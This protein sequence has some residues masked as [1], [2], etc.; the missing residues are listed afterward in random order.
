MTDFN[1]NI[2]SNMH[3]TAHTLIGGCTGSGKSVLINS[4]I[5]YEYQAYPSDRFIFIDP[6]RV[7]LIKYRDTRPCYLYASENADIINALKK[8]IDVMETAY[9]EM[10]AKGLNES[11][12]AHLYVVIDELADLMTQKDV[13]AVIFPM[14]QRIA[15]LGR[16]AHIHLICATQAP[17]RKVIPAELTLNFTMRIALRCATA[18]ESKQVLNGFDGAEDLPKYGECLINLDGNLYR[19][20]I[21]LTPPEELNK[22]IKLNQYTHNTTPPEPV[23]P[24]ATNRISNEEGARLLKEAR[25]YERAK[26]FKNPF[27]VIGLVI[28]SVVA[29]FALKFLWWVISLQI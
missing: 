18:I 28:W 16:A 7:E 13:R 14:L 3:S 22:L 23:E 20:D 29:F 6:K 1:K 10:Q 19:G 17:S 26:W 27:N 25:N 12:K 24:Q 15:Q 4:F 11:D 2:T 21:A 5:G 8:A 9:R